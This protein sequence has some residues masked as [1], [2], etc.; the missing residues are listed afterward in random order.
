MRQL[1]PLFGVSRSAADRIIGHLG[2]LFALRPRKRFCMDTVLIV[3]GTKRQG[4]IDAD[5]RLVVVVR[6][7]L[8]GNRADCKGWAESGA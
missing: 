6:R 5:S 4:I 7:L 8:P 1:T 2:P 3:D